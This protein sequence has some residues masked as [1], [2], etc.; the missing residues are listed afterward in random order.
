MRLKTRLGRLTSQKNEARRRRKF[1]EILKEIFWG[2]GIEGTIRK[3]KIRKVNTIHGN[4]FGQTKK[5]I[6][7]RM[8]QTL[9]KVLDK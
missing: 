4:F 9:S 2:T 7:V 3:Y 5:E 6:P 1:K 8:Q